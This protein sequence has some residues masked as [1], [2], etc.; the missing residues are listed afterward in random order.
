MSG[1]AAPGLFAALRGLAASGVAMVRTRLE[2]LRVEAHGELGRI[3][4]LI[5]WTVAAVLCGIVGAGFLAAWI[6]VLLWDSQRLLA[7][8]L[9][10]FLFLGMATIAA[11]S[12]RRLAQQKSQLFAASLAELRADESALR[13]Q[14]ETP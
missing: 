7:L 2:L 1:D 9:F 3:L 5:A 14:N 8:A 11:F 13:E 4:G 12:A 6:T 10:S